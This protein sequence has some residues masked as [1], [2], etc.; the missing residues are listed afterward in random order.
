MKR[1]KFIHTADLHLD[2]RFKGLTDVPQTIKDD[3]IQSSFRTFANMIDY[4]ISEQVS[5]IVIS[6]DLYDEEQRSLQ[7]QLFLYEQFERLKPYQIQVFI[8]HGNH[9]PLSQ[10][11]SL[12]QFGEHVHV[13]NSEHVT[14]QPAYH[15]GELVAYIYGISYGAKAVY[16]NLAKHYSKGD[17]D[18]YHLAMY[19][20]TVG[21]THDHEPYAPCTIQD[22]LVHQFDY[23]ALGHI[24]KPQIIVEN[25]PIV[26]AG[27]I[28]GRHRKELGERGCYLV[29][30]TAQKQSK[31]S[32]VPFAM[33]QWETIEM[34]CSTIESEQQLIHMMQQAIHKRCYKVNQHYL[35]QLRLVG[36]TYLH[37]QLLQH[38]KQM[39]VLDAI[40]S[41]FPT[42][43]PWIYVGKLIVDTAIMYDKTALINEDPFLQKLMDNMNTLNQLSVEDIMQVGHLSELWQHYD[44]SRLLPQL[45]H[46]MIDD[47]LEEATKSILDYV[48]LEKGR[49]L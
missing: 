48:A 27:N 17:E 43:H 14:K 34:D 2:S 35:V 23:V 21:T 28:Q 13:F 37:Q 6:G 18:V 46:H 33:I 30:V 38:H 45:Q 39:D 1:F 12:F 9:D 3:L 24:H 31:L 42:T 40:R 19:H 16:E 7:A 26:Y 10:K 22:L 4:A 8:I 25:P 49:E 15:Q 44:L 36:T 29:E 20:G 32:F 47:V 5:F 11:Q 41:L